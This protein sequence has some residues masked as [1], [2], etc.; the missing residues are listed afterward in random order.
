MKIQTVLFS[1]LIP[2][3]EPQCRR[4]SMIKLHVLFFALITCL[5]LSSPAPAVVYV[6][7]FEDDSNPTEPGFASSIFNHNIL[8]VDGWGLLDDVGPPFPSG[9]ALYLWP[10]IDEITFDLGPGE[11]VDYAAIDFQ[12]WGG[13]T[14]F[15]V[16]GTLDSF[17]VQTSSSAWQTVDTTGQ[18]L[19]Q[20][21]MVRLSSY[22][23]GFDNLTINVVPE[24]ATILLFGLGTLAVLRKRRT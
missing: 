18:N 8:P 24:P 6:E 21:T 13:A 3:F 20:I 1:P 10:A 5:M 15:D 14:T 16:I 19:G 17:S 2:A 7:N 23:G 9:Y 12:D 4:L 22:E 11:Y